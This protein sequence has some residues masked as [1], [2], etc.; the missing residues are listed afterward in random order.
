MVGI[1]GSGKST[2]AKIIAE[3]IKL[4]Q[5]NKYDEFGRTDI[6][7]IISSD[8]IRK[9]LYNDIENTNDIEH[10]EE[11][12]KVFNQ[13][14]RYALEHYHHVILDATNLSIKNRKS[15]HR[16]FNGVHAKFKNAYEKIAYV[17][18]TPVSLCKLN[19]M[20]REEHFVP[21][22]VVERQMHKFEVP[23]YEE[24]FDQI[25]FDGWDKINSSQ[26]YGAQEE[27]IQK[28]EALMIGFNQETHHHKY[29]L[30]VHCK[31][32]TEEVE[33][34]SNNKV[35]IRAARIHDIG[36][37]YTK[38]AKNDDSGEYSY[39][40]HNN[41]GAYSLL[42]NL[43]AVGFKNIEDTVLLLF[44]VNYHMHPFFIQTPK[45]EKKWKDIFSESLYND[46]QLFNE[47]DIIASGTAD[48][49]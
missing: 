37:L 35:L 6:I 10:N 5:V 33:K 3:Q 49:R 16:I 32:C 18:T 43:D 46:L 23:F 19:C 25:I 4:Q 22:Y 21:Q 36:K 12:F 7:D 40:G 31:K 42:Q 44:Y 29:T 9:E 24:G 26:W 11:V 1:S 14:V 8:A 34:R 41:V 38:T 28:I 15:H 48:E 39:H 30:D 27:D 17:M 2:K 20:A 13:R 45:A 47:C